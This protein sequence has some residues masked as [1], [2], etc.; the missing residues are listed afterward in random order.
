MDFRSS[1]VRLVVVCIQGHAHPHRY[2]PVNLEQRPGCFNLCV[3]VF[4]HVRLFATPRTVAHQAPL[5]MEF[6]SQE[7]WSGFLFP[8]PGNLGLANYIVS[9][10]LN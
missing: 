10:F 7:C 3:C 6:S 2:I 1:S 8:P 9:T 5:S 4:S